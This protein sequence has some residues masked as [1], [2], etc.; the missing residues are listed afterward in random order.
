VSSVSQDSKVKS[1]KNPVIIKEIRTRMRGNR[2]F[3]LFFLHLVVLGV[4]VSL[5][6]LVF[7]SSMTS[8]NALESRQYFGKAIFGLIFWME[9]VTVSFVAPA[10]TSGGISTE[11]ERQTYE[12]LRVTPLPIRSLVFGKFLSGLVF[13]LLLLFTSIPLQSPAFLVG[14]VRIEEIII[15]TLIL[16]ITAITFCAVGIFFSSLFPRT[17]ISSVLS[18]AVAIFLVFGIPMIA[19]IIL[20]LFSALLGDT[21]STIS[22]LVQALLILSGWLF[23]SIT[24]LGTIVSTEI[25]L[26][27]QH[28]PY[29]VSIPLG[30]G[31]RISLLSPWIPYLFV[32][33]LL[34]IFLLW[35]S[36]QFT[37]RIED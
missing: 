25:V 6:Y 18:Y 27:E 5:V 3:S 13:I 32:Y 29:F 28:N 33:F 12:I 19:L 14:G 17:L 26:L 10:L 11:R 9:M 36:I 37:K 4:L 24:P 22:P 23:V 21:Y 34:S 35:L 30:E 16:I 31:I 20:S 7:R 15:S 8:A 1:W 2:A